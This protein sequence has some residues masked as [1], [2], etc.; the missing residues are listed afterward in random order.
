MVSKK[1]LSA[2]FLPES[3]VL[4]VNGN[5]CRLVIV[6]KKMPPPSKRLCLH[7]K[8]LKI[9]SAKIVRADKRG[10]V[11]HEISRIN[12]LP[13]MQQVRLHTKELLYPGSYQIVLR[14]RLSQD[15]IRQLKKLGD[16]KPNRELVPSVDEQEAWAAA[17]YTV[18]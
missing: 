8:G 12:H 16:H 9:I 13:S 5:D 14:Y 18:N 6:G 10:P 11:E 2:A 7:Q 1:R 17:S 3:Y 15:K 4:S